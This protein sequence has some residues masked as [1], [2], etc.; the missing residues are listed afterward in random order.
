MEE[1]LL[2]VAFLKGLIAQRPLPVSL[3]F[4]FRLENRFW[5]E[6]EAFQTCREFHQIEVVFE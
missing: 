2:I 4:V 5:R 6:N 3:G 1:S